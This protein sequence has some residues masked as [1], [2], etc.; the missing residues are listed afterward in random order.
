MPKRQGIACDRK[1]V[2]TSTKKSPPLQNTAI[3][4][5][6]IIEN[7]NVSVTF[8]LLDEEEEPVPM[9]SNYLTIKD[10]NVPVLDEKACQLAIAYLFQLHGFSRGYLRSS[11]VC[12]WN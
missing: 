1:K 5:D 11:L 9:I 4:Q 8:E 7:S 6:T 12:S 2:T 10:I 3:N